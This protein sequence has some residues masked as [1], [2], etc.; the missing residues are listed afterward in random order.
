MYKLIVEKE[1]KGIFQSS[2]S[3]ALFAAGA[4][5]ILLSMLVG[6]REYKHAVRAFETSESLTRQRM[7]EGSNYGGL[8][9]RA[10]RKPEPMQVFVNGIEFDIGRASIID[11]HRPIKLT[12]SAYSEDPVYAVFRF[13]D[14][15]FIVKVVLSLFAI[16]MTY[17]AI[18]GEKEDG[19]MKLVFSNAIP[20]THYLLAKLTGS[21]LGMV[22]PFVILML[23]SVVPVVLS[24]VPMTW[25]H[26]LSFAILTFGALMLIT[27]FVALGIFV[28][29]ITTRSST[30]FLVLLV[31]WVVMVLIV[32]RV[33]IM[34]AGHLVS[35]PTAAETEGLQQGH[36]KAQWQ[37]HMEKLQELW[38]EREARMEG[39]T[40]TE[41]VAF[42]EEHLWEW[43]EKDD[44]I[45]KT[46]EEEITEYQSQLA[47]DVI[48]RQSQQQKLAFAFTRFSPISAF[49]LAAMNLSGTDIDLKV[50]YESA[51]RDY[52]R[53]FVD[54]KHKKAEETGMTGNISIEINT[55]SGV[56]IDAGRDKG[57]IDISDMPQFE[58][59]SKDFSRVITESIV[60]FGLLGLYSLLT[61]AGAFV[62]F[63][64][65]D[66]R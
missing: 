51:M 24:G 25:Q 35:V 10:A 28:S 52:K 44:E 55:D 66:L 46:T 34:A 4:T 38:R 19:T 57:T 5:L 56:R 12:D 42:R 8:I 36:A 18:N 37:A 9:G 1:L 3:V 64:R 29:A 60:D 61:F 13:L 31:T 21:W 30:S 41:R 11:E 26:W 45:R 53:H 23:L 47:Q 33:S 15:S 22:V 16:L 58:P 20:R 27:F 6:I 40:K 7:Q 50:R 65:Y 32:P 48:N 43:M 49:Q 14:F 63:L 59:P 2:K 62:S 54:Y 17:N 39:M